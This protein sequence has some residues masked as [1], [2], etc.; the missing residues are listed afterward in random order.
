MTTIAGTQ[1]TKMETQKSV[2]LATINRKDTVED[3]KE[4]LDKEFEAAMKDNVLLSRT[5][6][7]EDHNY[8]TRGRDEPFDIGMQGL[9]PFEPV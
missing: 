6:T 8:S 3:D 5:L 4:L 9:K 2:R 7:K 1:R